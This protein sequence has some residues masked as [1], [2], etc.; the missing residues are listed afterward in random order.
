VNRVPGEATKTSVETCQGGWQWQSVGQAFCRIQSNEVRL[1]V[2][3]EL[4]GV[5]KGAFSID[6]KWIDNMQNPGDIL[7]LYT[8]GDTAPNGRFRYRYQSADASN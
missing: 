1:A 8:H 3:R 6:F 4:L 5:A 7:D 2:P